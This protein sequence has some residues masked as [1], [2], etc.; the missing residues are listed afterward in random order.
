MSNHSGLILEI[1][2]LERISKP[3]HYYNTWLEN[4]DF[5]ECFTKAWNQ[6]FE[7]CPM[8]ILHSWI[9]VVKHVVKAQARERGNLASELRGVAKQLQL[10]VEW[11]STNMADL[12]KQS[13]CIRLKEK[14]KE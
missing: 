7:G 9:N 11:W 13:E 8:F 3:F 12:Q 1:V 10:E 4:V 2:E 14:I 5:N 6:H